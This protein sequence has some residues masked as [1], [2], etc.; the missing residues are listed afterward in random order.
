[1]VPSAQ[2]TFRLLALTV[3]LRCVGI[4]ETK[5]TPLGRS[6]VTTTPVAASGPAL[7]T[8]IVYVS[9][10][11]AATGSGESVFVSE[12]S[13]EPVAAGAPP[14]PPGSTASKQTAAAS[15]SAT[16]AF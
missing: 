10:P 16:D 5:L 11:P 15:P 14:A 12:R 7:A 1:M 2:V 13:A 4:A 8:L 3:Q 9:A 6:S